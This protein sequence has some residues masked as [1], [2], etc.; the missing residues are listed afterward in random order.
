MQEKTQEAP[1][2]TFYHLL[3]F[4]DVCSWLYAARVGLFDLQRAEQYR[5]QPEGTTGNQAM[6]R[7][8]TQRLS[9]LPAKEPTERHEQEAVP[10]NMTTR[11]ASRGPSWDFSKVPVFPPDRAYRP[12]PSSPLAAT[13]LPGAI[14]AK[15]AVGQ[16][17]DPLEHE[18]NRVADQVMRMSDPAPSIATAPSQINRKCT[19]CEEE[20]KSTL[21]AK[22]TAAAKPVGG[23]PPL[24][25]E[26]LRSPGRPLDGLTRAYFEPRFGRDFSQVRVHADDRAAESAQGVGAL[27]YAVGPHIAFA[28]GRYAPA[29]LTGQALLAH[30]LAHVVQQADPSSPTQLQRAHVDTN[31]SRKVFDSPRYQGDTK[32]EACLNDEGRL[33]PG[34]TGESV[35]RTQEGLAQDPNPPATLSSDDITGVYDAKTG[36]AVMAFKKKYSLG[37]TNFPASGR[38][39]TRSRLPPGRLEDSPQSGKRLHRVASFGSDTAPCRRRVSTR[40]AMIPA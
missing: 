39:T 14:Q 8:L 12:Q 26:V 2:N 31:T 5:P 1:D 40:S 27:A 15:L 21:Q 30:E 25:H 23:A 38:S 10:E 7:Y 34:A 28:R 35:R 17:N 22:S 32:L 13:P 11:E 29:S 24:V 16:I 33:E 19:S 37:S 18:A 4:V 6:L 36:Q 3:A 9:N 20:E